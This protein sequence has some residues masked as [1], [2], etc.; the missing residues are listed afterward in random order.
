M[1]TT[2]RILTPEFTDEIFNID[3]SFYDQHD[4]SFKVEALDIPYKD[5]KHKVN[6]MGH[7]KNDKEFSAYIDSI[8]ET[9]LDKNHS[10]IIY[11][12]RNQ[13]LDIDLI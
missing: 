3:V 4:L 2:N 9:Y 1:N 5:D 13:H 6:M 8:V 10:E 11:D 12:L 7:Y